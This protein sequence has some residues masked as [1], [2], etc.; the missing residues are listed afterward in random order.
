MGRNG[1][2]KS[3]G[4][5]PAYGG[6]SN[7]F[8]PPDDEEP[9]NHYFAAP[10]EEDPER[11]KKERQLRKKLKEVEDLEK[12]RDA[13]EKLLGNQLKKLETKASLL[14][15][16]EEFE[17]AVTPAHKTYA[18]HEDPVDLPKPDFD[19][20]AAE[21]EELER[22]RLEVEEMMKRKEAPKKA[23]KGSGKNA[24]AAKG[25]TSVKGGVRPPTV[26]ARA[27]GT[28]AKTAGPGQKSAWGAKGGKS[29]KPG[30]ASA[31][32]WPIPAET[33]KEQV[34][35]LLQDLEIWK[36]KW[37]GAATLQDGELIASFGDPGAG[38]ELHAIVGYNLSVS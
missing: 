13:G 6:S 21:L 25:Q 3:K 27:T 31:E 5:E 22:E 35:Q 38:S 1:K 30:L 15:E 18:V 29:E 12:R 26:S 2:G 9:S 32:R 11:K 19:A 8:T 14:L 10:D 37:C 7:Y 4:D 17:R 36:E 34:D 24:G 28:L 33:P 16:M 20:M 23:P